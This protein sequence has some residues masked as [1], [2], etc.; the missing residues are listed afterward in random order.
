[1][2][3]KDVFKVSRKTFIDPAA[4]FGYGTVKGITQT[5]WGLVRGLF[6]TA[7]P[8]AVAPTETYAEA[9]Q[10]LNLTDETAQANAKNYFIFA[11]FFAALSFGVLVYGL[12]LLLFHR[13]FLG[14]LLALAVTALLSAQAFQ[15]H[16]WYFQVKH[17]KL[18]CT[19]DEWWQGKPNLDQEPKA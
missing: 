13:S 12:Y 16:F 14:F 8:T 5:L 2:A 15:L 11:L 4:W 17:R 18:G 6:V 19:F 9:L 3:L 10:R 1:M 7:E